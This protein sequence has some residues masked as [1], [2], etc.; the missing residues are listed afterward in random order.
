LYILEAGSLRV[1]VRDEGGIKVGAGVDGVIVIIILGDHDPLDSD[2][3]LFQVMCDSLLLLPSEG[4]RALACPC[5]IQG[6]T[7][8]SHG[9]DESLLLLVHGSGG[10]LNHSHGVVLLPLSGGGN[11]RGGGI[12]LLLIDGEVGG[13]TRHGRHDS[14]G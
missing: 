12:G 8:G 14:G 2:E 4:G 10:D 7:C 11:D 9:D 1:Q 6:L 3:L 5:L 13:T